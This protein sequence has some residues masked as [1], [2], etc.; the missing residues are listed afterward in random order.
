M[1]LLDS[2]VPVHTHV[3]TH[4]HRHTNKLFKAEKVE[5]IDYYYTS[6]YIWNGL[7]TFVYTYYKLSAEK[8]QNLDERK[9]RLVRH[10]LFIVMYFVISDPCE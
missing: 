9:C 4:L 1:C 5:S 8:Y 2:I 3:S 6:N 7:K 10:L